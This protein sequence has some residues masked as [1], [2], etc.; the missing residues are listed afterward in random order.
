MSYKIERAKR[1]LKNTSN[2]S[3]LCWWTQAHNG[4]WIFSILLLNH[5][6]LT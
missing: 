1:T 6:L 2:Y 5:F 4:Y 3:I